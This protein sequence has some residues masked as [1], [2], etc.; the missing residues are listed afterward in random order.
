MV[1]F[2]GANAF[3]LDESSCM[4]GNGKVRRNIQDSENLITLYAVE[5]KEPDEE[6][7]KYFTYRLAY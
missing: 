4:V 3:L 5:W 1:Y 2:S 7:R 6:G